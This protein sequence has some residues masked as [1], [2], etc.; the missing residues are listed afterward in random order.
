ML[1]APHERQPPV[2]VQRDCLTDTPFIDI[3]DEPHSLQ[4][5]W[6]R[7]SGPNF[8]NGRLEL[9]IDGES[10]AV[11]DGIDNDQRGIDTARLGV[12]GIKA[13]AQGTV[14]L[15]WFDSRRATFI[16]R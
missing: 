16:A 10:V 2:D 6:V 11:V 15:D 13:G 12:F 5:D 4:I 7:S 9:W 3:T 8:Q 14:F 1:Q